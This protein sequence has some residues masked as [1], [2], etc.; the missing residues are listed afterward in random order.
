[1]SEAMASS[2]SEVAASAAEV[3]SAIEENFGSAAEF[4]STNWEEIA[5]T[6]S[7]KML[8]T[9]TTVSET[10][11]TMST[12]MQ[13]GWQG[14][15][16]TTSTA[17]A[18]ML[19]TVTSFGTSMISTIQ[20]MMQGMVS[21]TTS[22]FA[23]M[24]SAADSGMSQ[25][26]NTS[27]SWA[28]STVSAIQSAFSS[29]SITIP[30]PQLPTINV[31]T[32]TVAVGG[33]SVSVPTFSVSWNA[34]GGIFDDP[35]IFQTDKGLQGVGEAGPEAILPLDTLWTKMESIMT[36]ILRREDEPSMVDRFLSRLS[37]G[38]SPSTPAPQLAAAGAGGGT[39]TYSPVYNLYGSASAEDVRKADRMGQ[40]EFSR[41]M[42]QWEKERRRTSF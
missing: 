4:A 33:S 36:S 3:Q 42:K 15:V 37:G 38:S 1:M 17:T 10:M 34:L 40:E 39:I 31:G 18:T 6:V 41:L 14:M 20:T 13:S 22:G 32:N 21:A 23:S 2:A 24:V 28:Q 19:T 16:T 35:T 8:E 5:T 9:Q 30:A 7:D 11:T 27:V 12:D 29:M 25:L 26:Y